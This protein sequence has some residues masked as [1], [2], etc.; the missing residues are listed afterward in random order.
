ME[1]S[2]DI[3]LNNFCRLFSTAKLGHTSRRKRRD[4]EAFASKVF[5]RCIRDSLTLQLKVIN[6]YDIFLLLCDEMD[7][8]VLCHLYICTSCMAVLVTYTLL[9]TPVLALKQ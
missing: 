6:H 9:T 3:T 7:E 1:L 4:S 5:Q 8:I 2:I